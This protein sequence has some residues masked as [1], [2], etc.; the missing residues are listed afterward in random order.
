MN[1]IHISRPVAQTATHQTQ[2][3]C[4][5]VAFPAICNQ[6]HVTESIW[7]ITLTNCDTVVTTAVHI[8]LLLLLTVYYLTQNKI[9]TVKYQ[10][11]LKWRTFI[12]VN[13][14]EPR[15]KAVPVTTAWRVPRLRMEERPPIWRVA[16]NKL[17]KQSR[18]DDKGWPSGFGVGR[19]A[20]NSSPLK[21]ILLRNIHKVSALDWYCGTT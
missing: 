4:S 16:A 19:G 6:K 8:L 17:N 9:K 13:W 7:S 18:T 20:N 2:F 12:K 11:F 21:R 5:N 1:N 14:C 15:D 3:Q 10:P